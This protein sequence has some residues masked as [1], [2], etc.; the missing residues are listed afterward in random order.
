MD[1]FKNILNEQ[2]EDA[3]RKFDKA[4]EKAIREIQSMSV[5]TAKEFGAGY[6]SH[7]EQMTRYAAEVEQLSYL[8]RVYEGME[9]NN[10]GKNI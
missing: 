2:I 9:E 5:W 7:I 3:C 6:A 1:N 8:F 4:K 10:D